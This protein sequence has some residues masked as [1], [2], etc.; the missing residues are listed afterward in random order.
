MFRCLL[1]TFLISIC[2][3]QVVFSQSGIRDSV[4][5]FPF[6][7][8]SYGLYVPG[9]DMNE[10][11]GISS[12]VSANVLYK[13]STN[14]VFGFTG[15]FIFGD[16]VDEPGLMEGIFTD[17]GQVIGSDGLYADVRIFQRGYH[18]SATFGK[19]FA[20][21]KPNPNSG[22]IIMGGPG[23]IQHKIR[24]ENIGNTAPQLNKEYLKGYDHL[25][26]GIEM[27]EFIGYVY[28]GNRQLTNFHA[29]FEFIQGFT[30]GRRDYNFDTVGLKEEKKRIDLLYG[31]KLGWTIPLY[32]K[33]PA[34]YYYY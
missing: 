32:K 13:T 23:F 7:G 21:K 3:G 11:F 27:H 16:K 20:F 14:Y 22:I 31:F 12:I 4:I 8:L 10:R 30:E 28:F 6:I 9:G 18:V 15:G 19:I 29:G 25:T 1:L 24:I 26:N 17:N 5:R 34:K 33:K 2:F